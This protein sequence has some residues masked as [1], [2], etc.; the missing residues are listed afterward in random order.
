MSKERKRSPNRE[1]LLVQ[2]SRLVFG[3]FRRKEE[4]VKSEGSER[5]KGPILTGVLISSLTV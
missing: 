1:I 5:R 3:R 2:T 4:N